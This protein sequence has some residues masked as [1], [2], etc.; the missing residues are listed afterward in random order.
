MATFT[1]DELKP[2]QEVLAKFHQPEKREAAMIRLARL[3]ERATDLHKSG[4]PI[5]LD[6][7]ADEL[8][9]AVFGAVD[10]MFKREAGSPL[11]D[12]ELKQRREAARGRGERST[13]GERAAGLAGGAA[14]G[15]SF[16]LAAG[17]RRNMEGAMRARGSAR[18]TEAGRQG[19]EAANKFGALT[20]RANM[21]DRTARALQGNPRTEGN[22]QSINRATFRAGDLRGRAKQLLKPQVDMGAVDRAGRGAA[23]KAMLRGM[24]RSGGKG[25][26]IGAAAAGALMAGER[27]GWNR[28]AYEKAAPADLRKAVEALP[29]AQRTIAQGMLKA[30]K[31][32]DLQKWL[33]PALGAARAALPAISRGAAAIGGRLFGGGGAARA[34]AAA[35]TAGRTGIRGLAAGGRAAGNLASRAGAAGASL[36]ARARP[37]LAAMGG[38][39]RGMAARAGMN[40][41]MMAPDAARWAS[42][43]RRGLAIGGGAAAAGAGGAALYGATRQPAPRQR[44]PRQF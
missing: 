24:A 18:L 8:T 14:I 9:K 30:G 13:N 29:L 23:G 38:R 37:G 11:S 42:R 4:K 12:A 34:G 21:L 43:N 22:R 36:M 1:E 20:A 35:M 7:G 26:A 44:Q 27:Y 31:T 5:E 33:G 15:A 40:A 3:A 32:E 10:A 16:G 39:M 41:A 28:R 19:T 2:I 17:M 25:A 6:D